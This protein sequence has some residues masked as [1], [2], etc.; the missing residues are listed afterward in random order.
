L[1]PVAAPLATTSAAHLAAR[2]TLAALPQRLPLSR[3]AAWRQRLKTLWDRVSLS[4][5]VILMG[6]LA[7]GS[8][9][10]LGRSPAPVEPAPLQVALQGPDTA[11][12]N[13][14]MREFDPDGRLRLQIEGQSLHHYPTDGRLAIEQARLHSLDAQGRLTQARAQRLVSNAERSIHWLSGEVELQRHAP[15][16]PAGATPELKFRGQALTLYTVA[17]RIE[18]K[19]PVEI[20]RGAHHIRADRMRYD[21]QSGQLELQGRVRSTMEPAR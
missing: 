12:Q 14:L 2:S 1:S 18:S 4:L 7:L 9:W 15:S 10:V 11:M 19:Q 13:V 17:K 8:Y 16:D 20:W 21:Q 5:P 6:L 3:R